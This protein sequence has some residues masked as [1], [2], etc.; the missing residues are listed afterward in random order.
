MSIS[1]LLQLHISPR[2]RAAGLSRSNSTA[3]FF[4]LANR[5]L[6]VD[7]NQDAPAEVVTNPQPGECGHQLI[8]ITGKIDNR[9]ALKPR[10]LGLFFLCALAEHLLA[11]FVTLG[12]GRHDFSCDVAMSIFTPEKDQKNLD[13]D[14]RAKGQC[15]ARCQPVPHQPC[16]ACCMN[17]QFSSSLTCFYFQCIHSPLYYLDGGVFCGGE[18]PCQLMK[19][20]KTK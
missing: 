16:A 18:V 10:Q 13:S 7:R 12:S 11:L 8:E 3:Y 5:V 6:V 14:M 15:R 2:A 19:K 1:L 9:F 4:A 20:K 17:M